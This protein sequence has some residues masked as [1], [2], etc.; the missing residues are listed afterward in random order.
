MAGFKQVTKAQARSH[1]SHDER[2]ARLEGVV[3]SL[4]SEDEFVEEISRLWKSAQTT[5]LTI[6]RYLVQAQQKLKLSD[7]KDD[8][9]QTFAAF[10]EH[11][12]PFGY[13]VAYQLRKVAEAVDK[14]VLSLEELP[15]SYATAYQLTTL[16]P[17]HLEKA[18]QMDPPLVRAD[19]KREEIAAFKRQITRQALSQATD[20]SRWLR[21]MERR[22][23]TLIARR[24]QI[25]AEITEIDRTIA[26]A[27]Q[28]QE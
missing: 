18:R 16:T 9:K 17:D 3:R 24:D 27:L 14:N 8:E 4:E 7:K 1:L 19:V 6:G 21:Q 12:L 25:L 20:S 22:R 5:F 23:E 15:S 2:I 13:Q 26:Q 10:V 11:R 28:H